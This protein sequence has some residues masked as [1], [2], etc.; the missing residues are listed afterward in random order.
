MTFPSEIKLAM[1]DAIL[2]LIWPKNDIIEFFKSNNCTSNDI[3]SLGSINEKNRAQ[4][5]DEM[6]QI[7]SSRNDG[8]LGQFRSM[9]QT[10]LTW[11]HFDPYYF[12]NLKKL[13]H[14]D[15]QNSI[16]HLKLLQQTRDEKIKAD[17][18]KRKEVESSAKKSI[19]SLNELKDEF[20]S[21]LQN[22]IVGA[23]R[24][25]AFE[26]LLYNLAIY[27]NLETTEPFKVNGEQIDGAIKFEGEHYLF[28]AKW[29]DKESSNESVYQFA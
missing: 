20:L 13:N 12:D 10:L 4:L 14:F 15:A 2:K 5:I 7:Q 9:L 1:R 25:Y 22:K 26:K 8:G 23:K 21:L 6:F 16:N 3:K 11:Q 17:N 19:K 18:I 28:E 24:G 29:Q 27:F